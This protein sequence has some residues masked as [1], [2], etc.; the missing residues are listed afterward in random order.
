MNTLNDELQMPSDWMIPICGGQ[1]RLTKGGTKVH[2]TQKP[3]ALLSR[4]LTACS[5]PGDVIL[6]PFFGTG[7]TGAVAQRLGSHYL[8]IAREDDRSEARPV[9]KACVSQCRYRWVRYHYNIRN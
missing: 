6:D 4:I 9:G 5:N 3:E 7:T 2:P 8:G 1:E